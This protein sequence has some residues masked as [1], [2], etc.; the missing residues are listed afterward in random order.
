MLVAALNSLGFSAIKPKASFY[1]YAPIPKGTKAGRLFTSAEDF[2]E[3]VI[4]E[5]L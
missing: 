2:S 1:L 5:K 3:Y 4:T